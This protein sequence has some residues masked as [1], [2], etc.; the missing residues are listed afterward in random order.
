[1]RQPS[2]SQST[3]S[4]ADALARAGAREVTV[5]GLR[6]SF[7]YPARLP[8][9]SFG[10]LGG[11]LCFSDALFRSA[12]LARQL[13]GLPYEPVC[14]L[15]VS[16]AGW[17]AFPGGATTR[18]RAWAA[19]GQ[20]GGAFEMASSRRFHER[21]SRG[22][23]RWQLDEPMPTGGGSDEF[24]SVSSPDER[25]GFVEL[26]RLMAATAIEFAAAV[27]E[28]GTPATAKIVDER[29]AAA[30]VHWTEGAFEHSLSVSA[31][32]H[33]E[34]LNGLRF[35]G[36]FWRD[37]ERLRVRHLSKPLVLTAPGA[38]V[39]RLS[40]LEAYSWQSDLVMT[41]VWEQLEALR[42]LL[43]RKAAAECW[44]EFSHHVIP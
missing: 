42:R 10:G 24:C 26:V 4:L 17:E 18:R 3:P 6:P 34:Y 12:P 43:S 13:L 38:V 19:F 27:S 28:S 30:V 5:P 25:G 22:A 23:A 7:R 29:V 14:R 44:S 32:V 16:N 39:A 37:D 21:G 9:G 41:V 31:R 15:A 1:M 35:W 20:P 2:S 8:R 33:G 36:A 11:Q 40:R